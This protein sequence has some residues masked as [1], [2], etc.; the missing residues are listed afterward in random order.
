MVEAFPVFEIL[1]PSCAHPGYHLPIL[2]ENSFPLLRAVGQTELGLTF[3]A[4]VPSAASDSALGRR[5]QAKKDHQPA[6]GPCGRFAARS[7]YHGADGRSLS[8]L[9]MF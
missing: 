6:D 7:A 4:C 2:A 1:D 8:T 9:E 5:H 3:A